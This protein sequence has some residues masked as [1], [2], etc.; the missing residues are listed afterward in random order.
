MV[1]FPV[2]VVLELY[3]L[4]WVILCSV[5]WSSSKFVLVHMQARDFLSTQPLPTTCTRMVHV[6]YMLCFQYRTDCL[7]HL[8]LQVCEW[9]MCLHALL[10]VQD[11]LSNFPTHSQFKQEITSSSTWCVSGTSKQDSIPVV[12]LTFDLL[13]GIKISSILINISISSHHRPGC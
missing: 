4:L 7:Q 12:P 13:V 3:F 10:S 8:P 2:L 9:C 5:C 11:R 6:F 1:S